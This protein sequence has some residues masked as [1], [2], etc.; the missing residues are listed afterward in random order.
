MFL[1]QILASFSVGPV[2]VLQWAIYTD[3]ADYSE[4]KTGR[5]ATALIMAASLFCL[6]LGIA[7]AGSIQAWIL[8]AIGFVANVAQ[9]STSLHGIRM[10]MSVI[11]AAA[12]LVA[13]TLM[14]FYPLNNKKMLQIEKEL[15]E[16]RQKRG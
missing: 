15:A 9:S 6:K 8:S 10:L 2:S 7:L 4:W 1:L 16:R 11:P 14:L 5:R 13:V 3:T 12:G